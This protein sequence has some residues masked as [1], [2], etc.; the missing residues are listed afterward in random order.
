MKY[1]RILSQTGAY[2][3]IGSYP[4]TFFNETI[5]FWITN[6][7]FLFCFVKGKDTVKTVEMEML[8]LV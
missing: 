1:P 5:E 2:L 4:D 8:S 7:K 6:T 3:C